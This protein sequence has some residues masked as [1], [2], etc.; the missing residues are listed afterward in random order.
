[1]IA[2]TAWR[3]RRRP[4]AWLVLVIIAACERGAGGDRPTEAAASDSAAVRA[5]YATWFGAIEAGDVERA[6]SV[7]APDVVLE[8]PSGDSLVDH[9]GVR[10]A[11]GAFLEAYVERITWTLEIVALGADS[12][13]V[14]VREATTA[15]PRA[16]GEALR[17]RGW[18]TGHL[19]RTDGAWLIVR[20]IAALDGP[21]EPAPDAG[22][23]PP[24]DDR[25]GDPRTSLHAS[26][27]LRARRTPP[28]CSSPAAT[29]S[30]PSWPASA[31]VTR[32]SRSADPPC[33]TRRVFR[34]R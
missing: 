31:A 34:A 22:P 10:E 11:L 15:W 16:G 28:P 14:R 1:M 3:Q 24:S 18:H 25:L 7:L 6:L 33:P 9:E 8:S 27:A 32:S 17:V 2:P 26:S 30:T 13:T 29:R 21:P 19:R 12:A 4:P 20:D 23:A 5:A